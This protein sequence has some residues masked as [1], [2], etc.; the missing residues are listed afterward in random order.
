MPTAPLPRAAADLQ[1]EHGGGRRVGLVVRVL[2]AH[3]ELVAVE[4]L[5]PVALLAGLAGGRRCCTGEG[6]G[7]E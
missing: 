2:G 6:M 3:H 4:L 7:R 5:R 1:H